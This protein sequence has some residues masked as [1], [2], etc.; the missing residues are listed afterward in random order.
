[1]KEQLT[2]LSG[3]ATS[4][5][6]QLCK[7]GLDPSEVWLADFAC[8]LPV[9]TFTFAV[10]SFTSVQLRRLRQSA[11]RTT[12]AKFCLNRNISRDAAFGSPPRQSNTDF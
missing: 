12:L 5:T 4:Y 7:S 3:Q 9:M 1:M 10:T 2:A 8:F 6:Q 11:A